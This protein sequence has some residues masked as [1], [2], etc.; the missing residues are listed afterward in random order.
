M[1]DELKAIAIFSKTIETGSF[2]GCAASLRLSPSVVSHHIAQLEQKLGLTLLYRSTRKMSL[3]AE[4]ELLYEASKKMLEAIEFGLD[5]ILPAAKNPSGTLKVTMPSILVRSGLIEK[6]A[7]FCKALPN[8]KLHLNFTDKVV[9]LIEERFDLGIRIGAL[10]ESGLMAKKLFSFGRKLV[11]SPSFFEK[12]PVIKK[13][14]ELCNWGWIGIEMLPLSRQFKNSSGKI[15]VVNYQANLMCDSVDAAYQLAIE[16]A[17]LSSP[18][19]FLVENDIKVGK[20][21]EV[22]PE[23]QMEPLSVYAVWPQNLLKN[24]LAARLRNSLLA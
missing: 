4:G 10:K 23:W 18:P 24:N 16:G 17:G 3:T 9:D 21:V 2:R 11:C 13:P 1:F 14:E 8:V 20:L 19:D 6:I 7:R 5:A 22:L 12:M 15:I